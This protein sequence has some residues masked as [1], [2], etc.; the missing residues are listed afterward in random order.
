[1][2]HRNR[3]CGNVKEE[4]RERPKPKCHINPVQQSVLPAIYPP[5]VFDGDNPVGGYQCCRQLHGQH[6]PRLWNQPQSRSCSNTSLSDTAFSVNGLH[7]HIT[8]GPKKTTFP[9]LCFSHSSWPANP[10]NTRLPDRRFKQRCCI[11][12]WMDPSARSGH[13]PVQ[14]DRGVHGCRPASRGRVLPN[15]DQVILFWHLWIHDGCEPVRSH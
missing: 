14:P 7:S 8:G 15:T 10:R 5:W 6:F 11:L 1:M 12:I 2:G 13:C 9:C 4:E 3:V